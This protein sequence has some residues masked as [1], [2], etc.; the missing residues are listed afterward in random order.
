[1]KKIKDYLCTLHEDEMSFVSNIFDK[2]EPTTAKRLLIINSESP[3]IASAFYDMKLFQVA[4]I[5]DQMRLYV[6]IRQYEFNSQKESEKESILKKAHNI[7]YNRTEEQSRNYGEIQE[8]MERASRI[9]THILG[10]D[11]STEIIYWSIVAIKLSR[12]G[13]KHKEDNLLDAVAY[14]SALNDH[15]ENYKNK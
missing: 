11:I 4:S 6:I 9:A 3:G 13:Y 14:M 5:I 8:S 15:L 10:Q 2:S 7:V 1:M 12:E